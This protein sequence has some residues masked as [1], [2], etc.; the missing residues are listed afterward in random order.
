MTGGVFDTTWLVAIETLVDV[1][2]RGKAKPWQGWQNN[3]RGKVDSTVGMTAAGC[4]NTT[5]EVTYLMY[6]FTLLVS[7]DPSTARMDRPD[8]P[9]THLNIV[10][11]KSSTIQNT[12]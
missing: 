6:H 12:I 1:L 3:N 11:P 2:S 8:G 4:Q 7:H 5:I 9:A 10:H